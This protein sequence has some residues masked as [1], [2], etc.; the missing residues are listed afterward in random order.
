MDPTMFL[1]APTRS[2]NRPDARQIDSFY[3]EHGTVPVWKRAV[4]ALTALRK[5]RATKT[6]RERGF[7]PSH[8]RM[9]D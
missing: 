5:A 9:V 6:R 4:A 7:A 8:L 3:E 2:Q 1:A